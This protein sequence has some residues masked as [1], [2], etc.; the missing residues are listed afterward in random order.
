[1][2]VIAQISYFDK[3][4]KRYIKKGESLEVS[5]ERAKILLAGNK[6]SNNKPFV[7]VESAKKKEVKKNEKN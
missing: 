6:T 4:Q 7:A 5:E 2:K 3:E 1:M